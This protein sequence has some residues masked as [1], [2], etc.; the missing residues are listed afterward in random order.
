M[1]AFLIFVGG[2]LGALLRHLAALAIG[3]PLATLVI[4]VGG[5]FAIGLLAG[6]LPVDHPSR[7]LVMTGLLGGF[8]T[9]S[10]FSLDAV[11]LAQRG[12]TSHAIIYVGLTV[13][14][15]LA[16]AASGVMLARH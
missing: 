13:L 2:G 7:L 16:A 11:A 4:N 9:F 10:A 15:S 3:G 12:Q 6:S 5:S 8:T 14:L 1:A